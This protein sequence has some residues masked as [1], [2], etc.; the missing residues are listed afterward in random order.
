MSWVQESNPNFDLS[1]A[2][3]MYKQLQRVIEA[4]RQE[5]FIEQKKLIDLKRN[6]SSYIK[7]FPNRIFLSDVKEI[8]IKI[9][10]SDKTEKV[11]DTGK[12]DDIDLF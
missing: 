7:V 3:D 11:F 4:N 6:H 12:E 8:E 1:G 2:A 10:T 9:I 5:F